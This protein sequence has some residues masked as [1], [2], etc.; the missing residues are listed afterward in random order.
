MK[1]SGQL[2]RSSSYHSVDADGMLQV[3]RDQLGILNLDHLPEFGIFDRQSQCF[4]VYHSY[5][6]CP[7]MHLAGQEFWQSPSLD[8]FYERLLPHDRHFL[9][10]SL[11]EVHQFLAK[12]GPD[13]YPLYR[14][15]FDGCLGGDLHRTN[16]IL[17]HIRYLS[18]T[19]QFPEGICL[20]RLHTISCGQ[21]YTLPFR[22]FCQL[23]GLDPVLFR[24]GEGRLPH[25]SEKKKRVLRELTSGCGLKEIAAR[26]NCSVNTINN[27]LAD[28]RHQ[29][30]L[31]NN[32]QLIYYAC[33]SDYI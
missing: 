16:R 25:F 28:C 1:G 20:F 4:S 19:K 17:V 21:H 29:L 7:G 15:S 27:M 26:L 10:E 3:A 12:K 24:R 22:A 6:A 11:T 5:A 8:Y 31:S 33:C 13:K 32:T 2:A 30:R 18:P 14:L 9:N 23:P